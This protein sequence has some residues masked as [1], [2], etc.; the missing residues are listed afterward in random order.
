MG[1]SL[2]HPRY[3]VVIVNYNS[4]DHVRECAKSLQALDLSPTEILVYDNGST[5]EDKQDLR[6]LAR[7]FGQ[8]KVVFGDM[9]LGFGAG[10][11]QAVAA[12]ESDWEYVWILN[13]DIVVAPNALSEL[14]NAMQRYQVEIASPLILDAEDNVWFAGGDV[15]V[16]RGRSTHTGIGRPP[17]LLS[18]GVVETTFVTGAAPLISRAAWDNLNGFRE[19]LFLYWED[20]D[21][22]LRAE[23][24]GYRMVVVPQ[25]RVWHFQGGSSGGGIGP[26]YIYYVQKNRI[27]LFAEHGHFWTLLFGIGA[28][29]T[30]K[31]CLLPFRSGPDNLT[32][33]CLAS[34]R[35]LAH[36]V[37]GMR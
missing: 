35:G 11:N 16:R 29:E 12:A 2:D 23:E 1:L 8:L 22:S 32:A 5:A 36:G 19:D 34:V 13:P 27:I 14:S 15:D 20:A 21:L 7:N 24:A 37:R 26:T 18:S 6:K 3:L 17:T 31:L 10:V 33:K 25:A 9:N 30:L 4:S 28:L